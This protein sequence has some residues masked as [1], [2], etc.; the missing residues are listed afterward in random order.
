MPVGNTARLRWI[1]RDIRITDVIL[2]IAAILVAARVYIPSDR[3][4]DGRS[5][6]GKRQV[7][8]DHWREAVTSPL[9]L[10]PSQATDTIVEF[11]DFE[12]PA[13]AAFALR[14]DSL[15]SAGGRPAI[16]VQHFTLPQHKFAKPAA[17]ASE[18]AFR[19]NRFGEMYLVLFEQRDSVGLKPWSRLAV[20]AGVPDTISF[21]NC[22]ALP[23]DSF[24]RIS[25]G[26]ALGSKAGVDRTPT[27]WHNRMSIT[28]SELTAIISASVR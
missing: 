27:V 26:M 28:W 9:R 6:E 23:V 5:D 14:M 15:Q 20:D 1:L 21:N 24:P 4:A 19:Q 2:A 10:G 12:C 11:M 7:A 25:S 17:I 8:G 13:C 16:F 3:T 22:T 18:C